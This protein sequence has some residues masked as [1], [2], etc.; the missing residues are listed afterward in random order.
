MSPKAGLLILRHQKSSNL[1]SMSFPLR[2][3]ILPDPGLPVKFT[4]FYINLHALFKYISVYHELK[5]EDPKLLDMIELR[6]KR[7]IFAGW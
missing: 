1:R 4:L 2:S 3:A 7:E 6:T 5:I